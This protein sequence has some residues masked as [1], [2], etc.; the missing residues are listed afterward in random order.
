VKTGYAIRGA[1]LPETALV[2]TATLA[3]VF[4]TIQIGI[5]GYLQLTVD[6][7]A[8]IA[9]H[10]YAL[11]DTN[12]QAVAQRPFP[13]IQTPIYID[14]NN[15]NATT[16][17]VNYNTSLTTQRHGGVSLVR[18]SHLEAT[19][20]QKA[21]TGLLGVGV[22]G[23]S[24]VSLHGS[25]I[26]PYNLVSNNVYDVA[27]NGYGGTSAQLNY[28]SNV[29]NAPANYISSHQLSLCTAATFGAACPG[30]AVAIWSLGTAEFLDHD[31]WARTNLGVGPYSGGYTF[32]EML[33]HQQVFAQAAATVFR[34]AIMPLNITNNGTNSGNTIINEI[35]GWDY[36][37][38]LGGG[39]TINE[40]TYGKSPMTPGKSCP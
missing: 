9:A 17:A 23:L 38:S 15:P 34:P 32:G 35:R 1:A 27:A 12:Y 6:G 31:N 13:S 33:C 3:M 39:Y 29:Q 16:V 20:T 19:V 5:I 11:G 26:E 36:E 8:F 37:T 18:G 21:P 7:A 10:E 30:N 4:G 24:G 2:L 28:F 25:A 14:Q 22:A 40:T